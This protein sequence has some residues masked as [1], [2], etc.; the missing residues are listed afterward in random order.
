MPYLLCQLQ[1]QLAHISL[2][3]AELDLLE[4]GDDLLLQAG[5]KQTRTTRS[6]TSTT[7]VTTSMVVCHT[8]THHQRQCRLLW[9]SRNMLGWSHNELSAVTCCLLHTPT[10]VATAHLPEDTLVLLAQVDEG[11]GGLG[12][13]DVGQACLAAQA[14]VVADNLGAPACPHVIVPAGKGGTISLQSAPGLLANKLLQEV[15]FRRG[16][17]YSNSVCFVPEWPDTDKR[18]A[19]QLT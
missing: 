12:V 4:E 7:G 2:V 15:V 9:V 1:V 10:L 13:P 17:S 6:G 8:R 5:K 16:C 3:L 18:Q 19:L 14:Q 11:V